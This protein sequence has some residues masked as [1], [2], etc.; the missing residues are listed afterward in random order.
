MGN[1]NTHGYWA[2]ARNAPKRQNRFL[3]EASIAGTNIEYFVKTS[4]R[5][6]YTVTE[7]EH[8][9]LNHKYYYPGIVEWETVDVTLVDP[10]NPSMSAVMMAAL[11]SMGWV[12]PEDVK[13]DKAKETGVVS[14]LRANDLGSL[15]ISALD[16]NGVVS[17]S[18]TLS[19]AWIQAVKFNDFD[20]SGDDL[21]DCTLTIR[22]DWATFTV[23]NEPSSTNHP[24]AGPSSTIDQ[25]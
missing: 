19:N 20:Y 13:M 2:V 1:E 6:G 10:V 17:E 11:A 22:F 8:R 25:L 9:F 5:P 21:M 7:A 23:E 24:G 16:A 3:F 14:K 12:S 4:G 18:W 15:K